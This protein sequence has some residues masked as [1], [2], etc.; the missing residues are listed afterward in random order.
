MKKL[1]AML[2]VFAIF[3]VCLLSFNKSVNA[4]EETSSS[5]P[6]DT[7]IEEQK[8]SELQIWVNENLGW[9][10]GIPTGTSLSI[11]VEILVLASKSKRKKE[12]LEETKTQNSNGKDIL[13]NAKSLMN[14][15]KQMVDDTKKLAKD[16]EGIV[17]NAITR[18]E[19]TDNKVSE[20]VKNLC[21]TLTDK[22]E[23]SLESVNNTLVLLEQ[24]LSQLEDVQEMMALHTK[25]LVANGTAEE[26]TKKIRG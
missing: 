13:N 6:T 3:C 7:T 9:L 22:L 19:T 24:R 1:K 23:S 5:A 4:E 26:I 20:R 16:L 25:E 21:E 2:F 14:N 11:L 8:G 10:I 17:A 12:E 15:T 18:I